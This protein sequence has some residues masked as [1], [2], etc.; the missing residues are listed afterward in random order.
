MGAAVSRPFVKPHPGHRPV[1]GR[2]ELHPQLDGGGV[3]RGLTA[4]PGVGVPERPG[5]RVHRVE[6]HPGHGELAAHPAGVAELK[7][8]LAVGHGHPPA[9]LGELAGGGA[10]TAGQR[11]PLGRDGHLVAGRLA[12]AEGHHHVVLAVRHVRQEGAA[13]AQV[14]VAR[15]GVADRPGDGRHTSHRLP[16][17]PLGLGVRGQ[18]DGGVPV[19]DRGRRQ[20][21]VEPDPHGRHLPRLQRLDADRCRLGPRA[22]GG[23]AE[24]VAGERRER[25]HQSRSSTG[26]VR[27]AVARPRP[28]R[29]T[30]DGPSTGRLNQPV[31]VWWRAFGWRL[32]RG[33]TQRPGPAAGRPTGSQVAPLRRL[34]TGR[35]HLTVGRTRGGRCERRTGSAIGCSSTPTTRPFRMVLPL[36]TTPQN[37]SGFP[38]FP[39]RPQKGC[40]AGLA[41][42]GHSCRADASEPTL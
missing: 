27:R 34:R 11:L 30:A 37:V 12:V 39:Y 8:E 36:P 2:L 10:D 26:C 32:K 42:P 28:G 31:V 35:V 1:G 7:G 21:E 33:T 18:L 38:T 14:Q 23:R 25:I 3:G 5:G 15:Q 9:G 13:A 16:A 22:A 24:Q 41:R 4:G 29:H 19:G 17:E 20:A 6:P 40:V